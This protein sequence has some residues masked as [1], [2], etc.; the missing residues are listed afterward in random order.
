MNK[1]LLKDALGWGF[2][3]WL[4]GYALGIVFFF[5]VPKPAIGWFIMP[6]GTIITL[7]VLIKKIKGGDLRYHSVLAIIW[8]AIAVILDY[9]FIVKALNSAEG[10]YKPDVYAYYILTFLLPLIAGY[11]KKARQRKIK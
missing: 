7:F 5:I 8:T 10:Y 1:Q 11:W 9:L 2:I 4:I 3:L 6:I